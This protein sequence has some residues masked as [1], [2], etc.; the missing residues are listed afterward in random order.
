[1]WIRIFQMVDTKVETSAF[2]AVDA[3]RKLA[4]ETASPSRED[5]DAADLD[6]L[7]WS[8]LELDAKSLTVGIR[9]KEL[10]RT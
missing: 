5:V 1:M 8:E 9:P 10:P 2:V 4:L 3:R 6:P 7:D